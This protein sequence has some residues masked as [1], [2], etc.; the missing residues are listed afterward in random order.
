MRREG[1]FYTKKTHI[2]NPGKPCRHSTLFCSI[3]TMNR[4][5]Q[6]HLTENSIIIKCLDHREIKL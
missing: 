4:F 5:V 6:Q 2:W 1:C 3:V